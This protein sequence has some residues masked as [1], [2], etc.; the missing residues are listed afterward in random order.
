MKIGDIVQDKDLGAQFRI[1]KDNYFKDCC[2]NLVQWF[3]LHPLEGGAHVTAMA[4]DCILIDKSENNLVRDGAHVL[5]GS[6]RPLADDFQPSGQSKKTIDWAISQLED[7]V[8]P[9][10]PQ[11]GKFKTI[12]TKFAETLLQVL[13]D[14]RRY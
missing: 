7:L 14:Q 5:V 1:V 4:S 12:H 10:H 2:G 13:K 6:G 9:H 11:K 3:E 8:S